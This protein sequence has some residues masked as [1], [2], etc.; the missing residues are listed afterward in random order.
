M[1]E[2]ATVPAGAV[3]GEDLLW[4]KESDLVVGEEIGG[5]AAGVAFKAILAG[6]ER[7]VCAKVRQPG[8]SA[9]RSTFSA[10][11]ASVTLSLRRFGFFIP[12]LGVLLSLF[13]LS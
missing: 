5:G 4:L 11:S 3:E 2:P 6:R 12:R 7:P 1:S 13:P 8:L 9:L 10:H